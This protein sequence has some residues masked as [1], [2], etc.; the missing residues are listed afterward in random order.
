MKYLF[1]ILLPF[2]LLSKIENKDVFKEAYILNGDLYLDDLQIELVDGQNDY[3]FAI[4]GKEYYIKH[5][6]DNCK[7]S[8][9]GFV[10]DNFI[11]FKGETTKIKE[12]L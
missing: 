10:C 3:W 4:K 8:N 12:I 6:R 11:V 1:V 5:Y 7:W 9:D 2:I